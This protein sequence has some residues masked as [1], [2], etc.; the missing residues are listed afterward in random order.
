[1]L[2]HLL[3]IYI[4]THINHNICKFVEFTIV[5]A[6]VDISNMKYDL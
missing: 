1:M 4:C 6:D 5:L 2:S 3:L